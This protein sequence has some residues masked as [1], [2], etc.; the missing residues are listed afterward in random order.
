LIAHR[1]LKDEN[2]NERYNGIQNSLNGQSLKLKMKWQTVKHLVKFKNVVIEK[3]IFNTIKLL[4]ES[5]SS[6]ETLY[7]NK[8]SFSKLLNENGVSNDVHFIN[9]IF[10]IF[11]DM[12][13]GEIDFKD[14][15]F[16]FELFNDAAP[17]EKRITRKSN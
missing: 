3:L 10:W 9:K 2:N 14:F 5:K 17:L 13:S 15:V 8:E 12:N 11:D 4:K 16:C 6:E 7:F 1:K